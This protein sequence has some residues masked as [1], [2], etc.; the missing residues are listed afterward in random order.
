MRDSD[1]LLM[2]EGEFTGRGTIDGDF[3]NEDGILTH[4]EE[5]GTLLDISGD[6]TNE[7]GD[8][9][10]QIDDM[11][12]AGAGFTRVNI[13]GRANLG[14][15]VYICFGSSLQA[16][17][18][19]IDLLTWGEHLGDFEDVVFACTEN[20]RSSR[21]YQSANRHHARGLEGESAALACEPTTS[22]NQRSFAVL[23]DSCRGDGGLDTI[24]PALYIVLPTGV[25]IVVLVVV[26]FGGAMWYTERERK[27]KFKKNLKKKRKKMI[28]SDTGA[29]TS[30]S[31]SSTV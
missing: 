6:F 9:F 27:K 18:G 19:R 5:D 16:R 21:A 4:G 14:G 1:P 11:E 15:T 12:N 25:G 7:K 24:E 31:S 8:L 23:F 20:H 22:T 2:E 3:V 26:F 10:I 29:T 13:G 30:A 28:A 17:Q